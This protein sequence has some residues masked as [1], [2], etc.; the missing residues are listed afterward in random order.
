MTQTQRSA[1]ERFANDL[2]AMETHAME[3]HRNFGP[4]ETVKR[5]FT[6]TLDCVRTCVRCEETIA[7]SAHLRGDMHEYGIAWERVIHGTEIAKMLENCLNRW[8]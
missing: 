7:E 8:F 3:C 5:I 6:E 4:S 2:F 1:E